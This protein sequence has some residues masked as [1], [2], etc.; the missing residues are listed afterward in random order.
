MLFLFNKAKII[1]YVIS[2]FTV[3]TLFVVANS[4]ITNKNTMETAANIIESNYNETN[5][6]TN[7][8]NSLLY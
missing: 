1:S 2:V 5:T 8:L 6:K 3:I 4:I 7:T